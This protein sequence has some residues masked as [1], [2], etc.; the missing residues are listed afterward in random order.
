MVDIPSGICLFLR[1]SHYIFCLIPTTPVTFLH[2]Y[3]ILASMF[4]RFWIVM[5]TTNHFEAGCWLSHSICPDHMVLETFGASCPWF[6]TSWPFL[7][8]Y[9]SHRW[10]CVDETP[11]RARNIF[12]SLS[13][14]FVLFHFVE[15]KHLYKIP[16]ISTWLYGWKASDMQ[17]YTSEISKESVFCEL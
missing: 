16:L 5:F 11:E 1:N 9:L 12:P 2:I 3:L 7:C 10:E 8:G 14:M 4:W 6:T 17:G 13:Q 15:K